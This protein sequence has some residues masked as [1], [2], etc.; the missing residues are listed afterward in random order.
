MKKLVK[1]KPSGSQK[2]FRD[3]LN[4]CMS[5]ISKTPTV[6][7]QILCLSHTII[8]VTAMVAITV[9]TPDTATS[10]GKNILKNCLPL[11]KGKRGGGGGG[12]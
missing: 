9:T 4:K 11:E 3:A 1:N 8:A 6:P 12:G 7:F 5:Q 2:L 10:V